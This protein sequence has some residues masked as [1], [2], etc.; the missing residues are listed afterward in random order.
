MKVPSTAFICEGFVERP[1]HEQLT[2][3]ET[4][5]CVDG[6]AR[7]LMPQGCAARRAISPRSNFKIC[8]G[9]LSIVFLYLVSHILGP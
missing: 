4:V 2:G 1:S 3:S 7:G 5:G 8:R 6:H 9:G